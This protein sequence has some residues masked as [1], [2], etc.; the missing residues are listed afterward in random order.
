MIFCIKVVP[1][2]VF[3]RSR[4]Y[5]PFEYAQNA[6][7]NVVDKLIQYTQ[8]NAFEKFRVTEWVP[9]DGIEG[10]ELGTQNVALKKFDNNLQI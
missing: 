10:C 1:T 2:T 7:K 8:I 6:I 9:Y 3:L 5:L 4:L